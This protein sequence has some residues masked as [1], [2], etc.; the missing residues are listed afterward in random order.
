MDVDG[1]ANITIGALALQ[2]CEQ[3][4]L[5]KGGTIRVVAV[6]CS[7]PR[8]TL[9]PSTAVNARTQTL[10]RPSV[11]RLLAIRLMGRLDPQRSTRPIREDRLQ[12]R[13][14]MFQL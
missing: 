10:T 7:P 9:T 4:S 14:A 5:D 3:D 12:I 13:H 6:A 2:V 8:N 11:K 1:Y